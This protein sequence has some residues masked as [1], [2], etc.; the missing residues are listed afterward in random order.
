MPNQFDDIEK[1]VRN[2]FRDF[3]L[4]V[5]EADWKAIQKNIQTAKKRKFAW[6]FNTF[7]G[8]TLS[9]ISGLVISALVTWF[10]FSGSQKNQKI[11]N[12]IEKNTTAVRTENAIEKTEKPSVTAS[13]SNTVVQ[14]KFPPAHTDKKV[15][16]VAFASQLT[17]G[18]KD[19]P[20]KNTSNTVDKN[21]VDNNQ[22]NT[23]NPEKTDI[24]LKSFG[25]RTALQTMALNILDMF[26]WK[27]K[28]KI[29]RTAI[30]VYG[31]VF[32]GSSPNTVLSNSSTGIWEGI[33]I[34]PGN[35]SSI[36]LRLEAGI[37]MKKGEWTLKAGTAIDGNL[38]GNSSTDTIRIKIPTQTLPYMD[39]QGNILYWLAIRWKDSTILL[40]NQQKSTWIELPIGIQK[41]WKAGNKT[42]ISAGITVLPGVKIA[43]SGMIA[44]PYTYQPGSFWK[45]NYNLA[46]DT[47]SL[48]IQASDFQNNGRIGAG[49]QIGFQRDAGKY[50]WGISANNRYYFTP[51]WKNGFPL[52][53]HT[54]NIGI[55]LNIGIKLQ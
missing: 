51:N 54:H 33:S 55:Q 36:N 29:K 41:D 44:N 19:K 23:P 45:Y 16:K 43:S 10:T 3:E 15:K 21:N 32:A 8:K 25:I 17:L 20:G 35:K 30:G 50:H 37:S 7:T 40:K 31:N 47:Q 49:L 26:D 46:A 42:T 12:A 11:G 6:W 53:Q 38:P 22:N 28:S 4:P 27:L 13:Q 52:K 1:S 9:L 14:P 24:N 2:A 48:A 18:S 34:T 5:S 39:N